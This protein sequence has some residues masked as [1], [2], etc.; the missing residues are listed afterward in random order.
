MAVQ[1]APELHHVRVDDGKIQPKGVHALELSRRRKPAADGVQEL[2]E[3]QLN[4]SAR[5]EEERP[6]GRSGGPLL[7]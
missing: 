6:S 2:F 4:L 3:L 1:R 7:P 5:D